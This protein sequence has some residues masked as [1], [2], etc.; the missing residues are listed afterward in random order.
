MK[1]VQDDGDAAVILRSPIE[2]AFGL[3]LVLIIL[4][5]SVVLAAAIPPAAAFGD[6]LFLFAV[7]S[8]AAF[9]GWHVQVRPSVILTLNRVQVTN[10]FSTYTME[11]RA[12]LSV[13]SDS[14]GIFLVVVGRKPVKLAIGR[15]SILSELRGNQRLADLR[16]AIEEAVTGSSGVKSSVVERRLDIQVIPFLVTFLVLVAVAY[17]RR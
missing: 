12:I 4:G 17:L 7:C 5:C 16:E 1:S 14:G 3:F 10:W 8:V 11:P 2:R 15:S 13:A 6:D 9:I